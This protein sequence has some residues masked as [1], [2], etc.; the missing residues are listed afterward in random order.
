[1]AA[2][3]TTELDIELAKW[4]AK[5]EEIK[6]DIAGMRNA[7]RNA[8]IG[9][10]LAESLKDQL[11]GPLGA[12]LSAGA[13]K[14]LLGR[15]DDLADTAIKLGETPEVLQRV[16][17][18]A[19]LS[20]SSVEGLAGAFLKLEKNLGDPENSK[21]AQTL[22]KYGI[23]AESL[24]NMPLDQKV[25]ALADAFQKARQEGT[26]V[27][28]LQ[29]LMGRGSAELIPLLSA[30]GDEL[31]AMFEGVNVVADESVY[32]MA[33]LN[34]ELDN[35]LANLTNLAGQSLMRVH[36]GV[37]YLGAAMATAM[38]HAEKIPGLMRILDPLGLLK[39]AGMEG[40]VEATVKAQTLIEQRGERGAAKSDQ[41]RE[42]RAARAK[43]TQANLAEA[44]AAKAAKEDEDA[45]KKLE[46]RWQLIDKLTAQLH[47]ADIELLPP[48]EKLEALKQDL[49]DVLNAAAAESDLVK[50]LQLQLDAKKLR[51]EIASTEESIARD[52]KPETV[53]RDSAPGGAV[54][55]MSLLTSRSSTDLIA[56]KQV[57]AQRDT[58][59]KLDQIIANTRPRSSPFHTDNDD[60]FR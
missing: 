4:K 23:T 22:E 52:E 13:I 25:L 60:T 8:N 12:A 17:R 36:D 42:D 15:F 11:T 48:P 56:E 51:R 47:E 46:E 41:L 20:G 44:S 55:L 54:D 59:S 57:A 5:S 3:V 31:R 35:V 49:K 30:S 37:V 50:K 1:M 26:G 40:D 21:A 43:A 53:T 38:A 6:R 58:N 24:I 34:D 14:G 27:Y 18:A 39:L 19:E 28:E 2:R 16:A 7:A 32:A 45:L 29:E 9:G 10:G 33:A